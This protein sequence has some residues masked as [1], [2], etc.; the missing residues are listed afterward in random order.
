MTDTLT[1]LLQQYGYCGMLLAAFLAG[2]FFPFSS[3]AVMLGLLAAGLH[4]IPLVVYGTIGNVAGSLFNY[5]VGRMGRLEWIERYL[6][7]KRRDI[8]KAQR[9]M[10]GHGAWM[11]FFAFLPIIGSAITI[12]LGLMRA[13]FFISMLS[14]T[15]GKVLRYVILM[16]S[17]TAVF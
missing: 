12:A 7:V 8:D 10:A 6:R 15:I 5:G 1:L 2:S 9:F 17:V 4:P 16:A 13:N 14:I 11:G 3:E